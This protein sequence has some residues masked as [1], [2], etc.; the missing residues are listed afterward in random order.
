[1]GFY[2]IAVGTIILIFG[3]RLFWIFVAIAGFLAGLGFSG[4]MLVNQPQWLHVLLALAAGLVGAFLAMLAQGLAF[5]LAGFFAGTYL[6]MI[7]APAFIMINAGTLQFY[8][9]GAGAV[10]GLLAFLLM[11][12]AIVILSSLVGA[13]AIVGELG[14]SPPLSVLLFIILAAAGILVQTKVIGPPKKK[15]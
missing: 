14:L 4:I 10:G 9:L 2:N 13:G 11:D 5:G 3:R 6:A 12:P 1:M 15:A 8:I 7:L